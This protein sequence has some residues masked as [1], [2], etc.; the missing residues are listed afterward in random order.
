MLALSAQAQTLTVYDDALQNGFADYSFG[1]GTS[2]N[3]TAFV[4][5]GTKSASILGHN[6]NA[7]S[8]AHAPGNV[9]TPL[10]TADTPVLRFWVNGG[11]ASGQ[12]FHFALELNGAFVGSSAALDTYISGG[13]VAQN[14]WRQVTIDLRQAPFNAVNFDRID[15][16]SDEDATHTDASATYFDDF[17]LGQ[18]DAVTVNPLQIE[19]DVVVHTITSDRFTWRDSSGQPRVASLAHNDNETEGGSN[20]GALREF[21]YQ[22]SNGQTRTATVTTYG[23]AGFGGFGYVTLHSSHYAGCNGDDSPL[24]MGF[25]GHWQRIFEGRHHAIFRFTQLYPRN[26]PT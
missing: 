6:F 2:P 17:V 13:G 7:I 21:K 12:Q 15:I 18:P 1:G 26:C 14:V 20:G 11:T 3:A 9:L 4:H 19:H 24:G 5:T 23:N 8:F 10:H 16:Q 22:L 25:S